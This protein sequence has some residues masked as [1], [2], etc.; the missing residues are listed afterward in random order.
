[1]HIGKYVLV[2]DNCH[3]QEL[4]LCGRAYALEVE[5]SQVDSHQTP[6]GNSCSELQ[7]FMPAAVPGS[8]VTRTIT[9]T[10]AQPVAL[11]F[12]WAH[13]SDSADAKAG[14]AAVD[15]HQLGLQSDPQ[16]QIAPDCGVLQAHESIV[17]DVTFAPGAV[18]HVYRCCDL[19][20][21]TSW[22]QGTCG[23]REHA[24]SLHIAGDGA[25]QPA[26]VTPSLLAAPGVVRVGD[27]VTQLL[28]V[29]NPS[30]APAQLTI[31]GCNKDVWA[32]PTDADV[33]AQS[34][35]DVQV[36][37]IP[38]NAQTVLKS[39]LMCAF[40]HGATQEV[41]VQL[42]C[43]TEPDIALDCGRI[44]LGNVRL[45]TEITRTITVH[46]TSPTVPVEWQAEEVCCNSNEQTPGVVV[47]SRAPGAKTR[48]SFSA[49]SGSIA[50]GATGVLEVTVHAATGGDYASRVVV[51]SGGHK[52]CI[53]VA[54]SVV[55][56]QL[57]LQNAELHLGTIYIGVP[58]QTS[59]QL[60]NDAALSVQWA[61]RSAAAAAQGASIAVQWGVQRGELAAGATLEVPVTLTAHQTGKLEC[62][63]AVDAV[64]AIQ[65]ALARV[66]ADVQ[67]LRVHYALCAAASHAE[68]TP[69]QAA[70]SA[71][72]DSVALGECPVLVDFGS[73]V[74]MGGCSE[75]VLEVHNP[76]GIATTARIWLEQFGISNAMCSSATADSSGASSKWRSD[77]LLRGT[78]IPLGADHEATSPFSA[79]EG[80]A[81]LL[82]RAMQVNVTTR[83]D[84]CWP[85]CSTLE[86]PDSFA[87]DP[88][89]LCA[90]VCKTFVSYDVPVTILLQNVRGQVYRFVAS[91]CSSCAGAGA[92]A[93]GH[94]R[95]RNRAGACRSCP[96]A[97]RLCTVPVAVLHRHGRHVH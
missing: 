77:T 42:P 70:S 64:G 24:L 51:S 84:E 7:L 80:N 11:P 22:P 46:N 74:P 44:A 35:L 81:M 23:A 97:I 34:E 9:I 47:D 94:Q 58:V 10:N 18:Q 20:V 79:A 43:A 82:R 73:A 21:D 90:V 15:L 52:H 93:P 63:L 89:A 61:A 31:A 25:P 39:T 55:A 16:V 86:L 62:L 4:A 69:F 8:S 40:A 36:H 32:D 75:R 91:S 96:A 95:H 76:T 13:R 19:L 12:R 38:R 3:I 65:P 88:H 33:P 60:R 56:P 29:R 37:A 28:R 54:A 85:A 87:A 49:A 17:C 57:R 5:V 71:V 66:R 1:M 45:H 59:L 53:P 26:C 78:A 83:A 27:T 68:S 48:C 14:S 6:N 41:T 2:C 67:G 50:P 92:S 30:R 72:A